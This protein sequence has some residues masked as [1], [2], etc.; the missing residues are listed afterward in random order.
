MIQQ[1][2]RLTILGPGGIRPATWHRPEPR[3]QADFSLARALTDY[4]GAGVR[5]VLSPACECGSIELTRKCHIVR[6]LSCGRELGPEKGFNFGV[7]YTP[8]VCLN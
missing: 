8:A 2:Y 6:C 3:P 1:L 5:L 7:I 4:A